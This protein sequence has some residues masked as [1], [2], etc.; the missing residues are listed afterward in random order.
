MNAR[1]AKMKAIST[2][3]I[4]E[5]L[6]LLHKLDQARMGLLKVGSDDCPVG[7]N[8]DTTHKFAKILPILVR[9]NGTKKAWP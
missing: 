8:S 5:I 6:E 7:D 2:S 1:T 9:K 3:L 4:V